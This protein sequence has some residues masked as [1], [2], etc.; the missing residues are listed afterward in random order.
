MNGYLYYGKHRKRRFG[1][2]PRIVFGAAFV[3]ALFR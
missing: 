2:I 3:V 1:L